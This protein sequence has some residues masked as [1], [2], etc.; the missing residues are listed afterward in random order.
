MSKESENNSASYNLDTPMMRQYFDLKRRYPNMLL[1]FRLGD[2]YE[3]FEDD[4]REVSALL[5]LTLTHRA[6]VPM[7][8]VPY[9][10]AESYINKLVRMRRR[11]AICDQMEDP[12]KAKGLVKREITRIVTPSTNLDDDVAQKEGHNFL[13]A[14]Y[15]LKAKGREIY[16]AAFLDV[17]TGSF[18]MTELP[19]REELL[20]ELKR[21]AP[22]EILF[23]E[24][25]EAVWK[26][27][28]SGF[29]FALAMP[30]DGIYFD[31]GCNVLLSHFSVA[32]L[33]GFGCEDRTCGVMC[34]GAALRYVKEN[35]TMT[36][37]SHIMGLRF[38]EKTNFMRLSDHT[39]RNLELVRSLRENSTEG[40]LLSVLDETKTPMGSRLL[41]TW[42]LA[43]LLDKG[44]IE[45]RYDALELLMSRQGELSS[46]K[47][48]LKNFGD[49][50]KLVSRL[51]TGYGTP[52]D[53]LGLRY[54]LHQLPKLKELLGQALNEAGRQEL[55]E[56]PERKVLLE[57]VFEKLKPDAELTDLLDRA[58]ADDP[59]LRL[60]DGGIIKE[61]FDPELD[62][63][64]KLSR[65]GRGFILELQTKEAERT[66]IKKLKVGYT[67]VFG[68]YIEVTKPNLHLVPDNYIRKQTV[69]NGERFITPEL[70]EMESRIL[71]AE[72]QSLERETKLFQDLRQEV[73]QKHS[74][75]QESAAAVARLDVLQ[76]IAWISLQRDY[77]RPKIFE[78]DRLV[79]K[80]GR[81]PVVER[82]LSD[83]RFVPN[84]TFLNCSS[85]QIML[86]TGPNMA[87]KSTYIR[88]VALL[89]LMAQSGCFIPAESAEIGLADQIFTRVGASDELS[90]GQSTFMVEMTETA[91]ILHN[92]TPKSLIIL[93]EIGRGT[94]TYDGLA[95]AWAVVD[96][97]N[98]EAKVK[99]R[100]LFATHYHELIRLE[101]LLPGV[102]NYNVAVWEDGQSVSF[103]H[104]I[105]RGGTN[106]S[107]GIHVAKLA[108]L[109]APVVE[110][111]TALLE[112]FESRRGDRGLEP[113]APE[114]PEANPA[115]IPEENQSQPASAGEPEEAAAEPT[116]VRQTEQ[117]KVDED[118]PAED[119]ESLAFGEE[120]EKDEP[121]TVSQLELF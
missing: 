59:P 33:A 39:R 31:D 34:A 67:K 94:S 35:F 30:I 102:V 87:G 60:Q 26:E 85:D 103:L 72:E 44:E 111:A 10:A 96:Y 107:Y 92:A 89:V 42:L 90:R 110:R 91:N 100:T 6:S 20:E 29:S 62:E 58:L 74:S 109:P 53:L 9:H 116:I 54:C 37:L 13:G 18:E 3:L 41:R 50:E 88:Q 77:R 104:E 76:N 114:A 84:D 17:A 66:G 68:Y 36:S 52:R 15:L 2:F 8:G 25:Q 101:S 51:S 115:A 65:D 95:I 121:R 27:F 64:R 117:K 56:C 4:A 98:S 99:A 79:I 97:L 57:D 47:E 1:F 78:D 70:K 16:G 75:I 82:L 24:E 113:A 43:P 38:Y 108:G 5:G 21:Q 63:L 119:P 23:P 93:D 19:S 55:F 48:E 28:L 73:M 106:R 86:I 61:G 83:K 69:V 7:C 80:A 81:H 49:L 11:V 14:I 112:S 32:S 120:I 40:T 118:A 71:H 12:K 105:V 22:T 46:L 45:K